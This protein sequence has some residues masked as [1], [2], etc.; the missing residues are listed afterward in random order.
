MP[1][2]ILG[3]KVTAIFHARTAKAFRIA[4]EHLMIGPLARHTDAIAR[5]DLRREIADCHDEIIAVI[6]LAHK[7]YDTVLIIVAV[8]PLKAIPVKVHLPKGLVLTI[9]FV[10]RPGVRQ[11]LRMHR[12]LLDQVPVQ[13]VIKI[14]F[15][16]LPEFAA[17]KQQLFPRMCHPVAKEA[18]QAGKLLPVVTRHLTDERALTMHDLIMRQRQYKIL[19]ERIHKGEG[20]LILVPL[21]IDGIKAHV[22]EH[23]VHPAHIPFIIET[24][25]AR[26]HRLGDERPGG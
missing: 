11:H 10:E 21:A 25:T 3:N 2:N 19:G 24:H 18:P 7:G 20:Q 15:N 26:I 9:E 17:H 23:I 8:N 6:G 16:E 4:V 5:M 14:P 22:I 13:T 1:G 12:I